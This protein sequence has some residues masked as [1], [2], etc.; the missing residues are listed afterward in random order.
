MR[1]TQS[2]ERSEGSVFREAD[3]SLA[4]MTELRRRTWQPKND[5]KCIGKPRRRVAAA[6]GDG[7]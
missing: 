6:Q 5:S 3:S 1:T 4:Q 7:A 2:P